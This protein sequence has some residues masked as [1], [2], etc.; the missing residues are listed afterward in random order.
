LVSREGTQIPSIEPVIVIVGPTASGKTKLSIEL[1]RLINASIVSADSMQIY[2][3]MDIGT[4][5][6]D[7]EEMSGI[8]HYMIDEVYPDERF[9]VARYRELAL[10]YIKKIT[11]EGMRAIVVGG[12]GL[13]I[14]S[15]VYNIDFAETVCDE[16]LRETLKRQAEEKGNRF[17]HEKLGEIDPEAAARIH[18]NDIKRIIRAIE[19]YTYTKKPISEHSR[20]SRLTSPPYR[21]LLFGLNWERQKLYERINKRVDLMLEKGL[22]EEVERLVKMGYDK[23]PTAMQGIGYKEVLSYIKG[24]RTLDETVYKLKQNTRRY[25]KRQMTWFRRM[26]E[27][28]WID[29]DEN[30]DFRALA[31]RIVQ[32]CIATH[33]IIL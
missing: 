32:E 4:A 3:Y 9:S 5:K 12:T 16:G 33:G 8:K 2:K 29:V 28:N 7:K 1:A 23:G 14:S 11:E 17:L 22:I 30:S 27:I 18:E 6:P 15:L 25:A 24:E 20:M 13:Y 19:V 26:K 10:G 31:E 21:F